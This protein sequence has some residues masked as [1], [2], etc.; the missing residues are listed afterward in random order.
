MSANEVHRRGHGEPINVTEDELDETALDAEMHE[1][2]ADAHEAVAQ[3]EAEHMEGAR[4]VRARAK[5]SAEAA[6]ER[7]RN[8]KVEVAKRIAEPAMREAEESLRTKPEVNRAR[9]TAELT[10]KATYEIYKDLATLDIEA[11]S[12]GLERKI[13]SLEKKSDGLDEYSDEMQELRFLRLKREALKKAL[14]ASAEQ[15]GSLGKRQ[16]VEKEQKNLKFLLEKQNSIVNEL[17]KQRSEMKYTWKF[18]Q[19]REIK[20][21]DEKIAK[22]KEQLKALDD[23]YEQTVSSP[24]YVAEKIIERQRAE[25]QKYPEIPEANI[26][27][28]DE[29]PE[30]NIEPLDEIPEENIEPLDEIPEENIEPLDELSDA[31]ISPLGEEDASDVP[32]VTKKKRNAA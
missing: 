5:K 16:I 10:Q 6:K 24:A 13:K 12:G 32:T 8:R 29:I 9:E 20:E 7:V 30:E 14:S 11:Y 21:L 27:P 23:A 3:K 19:W 26:E 17:T 28:F 4:N 1:A 2:W 22:E 15:P 31:D 18:W 25:A